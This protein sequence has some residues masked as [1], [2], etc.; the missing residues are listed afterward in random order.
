MK[1]LIAVL[2]LM[3]GSY[4]LQSQTDYRDYHQSI[5]TIEDLISNEKFNEAVIDYEKIFET[6]EYVFLKDILIA[7]QI[8]YLSQNYD[9]SNEWLLKAVTNGYDCNCI[10]RFPVFHEY[11][12]SDD[13]AIIE[14]KSEDLNEVYLSTINLDLHY[15]FHFRYKNEQ[16]NKSNRIIYKDV[17]TSNYRRIKELMDS[18]PFPSERIIGIDNGSLFPTSSG[19]SL[20][21]CEASN[22]K[23]IPTLLH[24]D[25]PITD[26][27]IEKFLNAI[28][29]GHLHPGQFVSI[30]SFE[31][32]HVSRLTSSRS[33]NKPKLP[34]YFFN[35]GFGKR[36]KDLQ[37]VNLDRKKFGICS[38]ETERKLD[39]VIKKYKL[40]M[41]YGYKQI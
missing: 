3:C 33:I 25:N 9:K 1:Y 29:S 22:S 5:V 41:S 16:E 7:A 36:T 26:I 24:Y 39:T 20:S 35:S 19:G 6:Y 10:K 17:V 11:V 28:K 23:V 12:K 37:R 32:N 2:F 34:E 14:S 30:Y 38:L 21:S 4:C 13:W 27:G 15:E 18:I 8:A 31:S 40:R